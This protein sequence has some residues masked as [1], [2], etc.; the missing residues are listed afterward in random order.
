MVQVKPIQGVKKVLFFQAMDDTST[1]GSGLRLAFQTEHTLT[2]ERET[3][4]ELTKDGNIKDTG[5]I[6]ASL[7]FT[8]YVA[9]N[10][11]TFDLLQDAFNN[12][13]TLQV[14]EAD[15]TERDEDDMYDSIYAQGKLTSFEVSNSA[16]GFSELSTELAINLIPQRGPVNVS[17][18]QFDAVQYAFKAFGELATENGTETP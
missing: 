6:N 18:A 3:I 4:E 1:D 7:S 5:E 17:E 16:D 14:W 8:S 12:N 9:K 13:E 2:Q 10:D 11:P 15:L